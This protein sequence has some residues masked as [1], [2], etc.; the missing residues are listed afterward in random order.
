[1]TAAHDVSQQVDSVSKPNSIPA[2]EKSNKENKDD[3]KS[4]TNEEPSSPIRPNEPESPNKLFEEQL[5]PE[6]QLV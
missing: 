5:P 2:S 6:N 4:A 1:M 3:K